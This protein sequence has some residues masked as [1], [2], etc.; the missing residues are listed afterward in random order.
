MRLR[1]VVAAT[2]LLHHHICGSSFASRGE[3]LQYNSTGHRTSI[4]VRTFCTSVRTPACASPC[5]GGGWRAPRPRPRAARARPRSSPRGSISPETATLHVHERAR[6]R[7]R[8]SSAVHR[9]AYYHTV[10]STLGY[11]TYR[12]GS[13]SVQYAYCAYAAV[14]SLRTVARTVGIGVS[15]A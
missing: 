6:A 10:S 3:V 4:L 2:V 5:S 12:Y 1:C 7:E 11:T 15:V 9:A 13:T 8:A 14:F